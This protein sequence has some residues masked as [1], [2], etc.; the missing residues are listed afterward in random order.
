MLHIMAFTFVLDIQGRKYN[1]H[2]H[3]YRQHHSNSLYMSGSSSIHIYLLGILHRR[4]HPSDKNNIVSQ[5]PMKIFSYHMIC[6]KMSCNTIKSGNIQSHLVI[7]SWLIITDI[8][9]LL[10][11]F[12]LI[13]T[14]TPTQ[15]KVQQ[16]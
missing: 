6:L 3:D 14:L 5:N 1:F 7:Y 11:S 8:A 15:R 2:S 12:G 9:F 13:L 16:E 4:G 10:P